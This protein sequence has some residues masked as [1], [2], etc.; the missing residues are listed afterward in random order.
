MEYRYCPELGKNLSRLVY[1][2]GSG[3]IMDGDEDSAGKCLEMAWEAGF[4]VFDSAH[5]YGRAE[6]NLGQWLTSKNREEM[7]ILD[8]GCNPGMAGS[9][10][11]MNRDTI[12]RQ[13]EQSLQKLHTDYID[14]YL[15][16]RDD[17][18]VPV[19]EIVDTLN[20]LKRQGMIRMFG[21]SNWEYTRVRDA[22]DYA[23][24][25]GLTAFQAAGPSCSI[26]PMVRDP[27]GRS[28]G[29]TGEKYAD[30]RAW[31]RK[32]Q[33]Y[34]FT[35]SSLGRGFLSGKYS[36]LRGDDI[37]QCL[38][39]APITEYDCP[40]N[41][42]TLRRAEVL[43]QKRNCSVSQICLAYLLR[44]PLNL[45]PLVSPGTREHIEDNVSAFQI[46]LTE[47]DCTWLMKT[48]LI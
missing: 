24:K 21:G 35:Y 5:S 34:L 27:W 22:C 47:E 29:L 6:E 40:E 46:H 12:C 18:A 11:V 45:Y 8:K 42:E 10:D 38:P 25:N 4:R 48:Q 13:L 3:R 31:Y 39:E 41:A 17:P 36:P 30:S 19:D 33:M 43:A 16:H 28:V 20:D 23:E 32:D 26:V 15:L 7:V 14:I 1:G 44:L 2:T 37:H 9:D